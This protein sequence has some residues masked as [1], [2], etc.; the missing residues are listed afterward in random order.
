MGGNRN[1]GL[2][3]FSP[4][5]AAGQGQEDCPLEADLIIGYQ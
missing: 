2:I 3:F 4:P 5:K 1:T